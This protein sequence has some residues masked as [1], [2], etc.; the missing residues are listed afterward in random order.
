MKQHKMDYVLTNWF[1]PLAIAGRRVAYWSHNLAMNCV[2]V[3]TDDGLQW[4]IGPSGRYSYD[5]SQI[6]LVLTKA[7]R[8]DG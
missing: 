2:D 7:Q 3:V 8:I 1:E 4:E 5:E 6:T